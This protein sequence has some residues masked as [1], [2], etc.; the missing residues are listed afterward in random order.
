MVDELAGKGVG[1]R[2]QI[3]RQRRGKTRAVVAGLVGRSEGW[4]KRVEKGQLL[5]PRLDMLIRLAEVLGVGDLTELT[6]DSSVP[7]G[8]LRRAGHDTVPAIREAIEET[9]LIVS[10]EPRPDAAELAAQA[11]SAWRTWHS[12]VS[13]R[14]DVGAVLAHL[15]RECSRAVRVLDGAERRIAAAAL[16]EVYALCEQVLAWVAEPA[17]VWLT[18]DRCMQAAQQADDPL[19]IAGAA[20][21]VGNVQRATQREE[22]AL[23][24]ANEAAE[25]LAP[26]L[27]DGTDSHRAMWGALHLHGSITA[28]RMGREG[29]ARRHWDLGS[30]AAR[31]LPDGYAHPWTVFGVAN[32]NITGVSVNVDLRQGRRALNEANKLD[33][34]SVPS[35]ERRA[36]LWMEMARSYQQQDD[37]T[38]TL[39]LMQRAVSVSAEAMRCHPLARGL[40]GELVTS[41]APMVRNEARAL[42]HQL[43][44]TA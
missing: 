12:S 8:M 19:V 16:S 36:R 34:D 15:I 13:P 33:P 30:D 1:E 32:A 3:V 28:A 10:T 43:G 42:A 14:A 6:G 4:L 41:G 23:D 39:S 26:R 38:G 31:R 44:I 7:L 2:I 21:V 20:W 29:D 25:L 37:H 40:I 11:A 18:A 27:E 22:E 17:L 35:V 24:L 9:P 5:P